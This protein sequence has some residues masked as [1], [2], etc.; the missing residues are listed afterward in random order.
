MEQCLAEA[1][2]QADDV[3]PKTGKMAGAWPGRAL[4]AEV[5]IRGRV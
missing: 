1:E 5:G 3:G 2:R 4:T